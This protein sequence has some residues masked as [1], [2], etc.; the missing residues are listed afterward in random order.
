M[1]ISTKIYNSIL[2][3]GTRFIKVL[4]FGKSDVQTPREIAP[5]GVD[6]SPIKDMVAIYS[7]T[8]ERGKSVIVGYINPKQV[9]QPGETRLFSLNFLGEE[10]ATVYLTKNGNIELNG[11]SDN[12]VKFT[13]LNNS[14][15]GFTSQLQTE[16]LA[17]STAIA[18]LGGTYVPSTLNFNITAS[19]ADTV[20]TK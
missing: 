15:N 7:E 9:A 19:K 11:N 10:A 18:T 12:L 5:F 2:K 14:V 8:S 13:P 20:K 16:L 4:R 17:I 6:S 1:L 3:N